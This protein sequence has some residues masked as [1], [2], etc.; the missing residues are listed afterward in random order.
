MSKDPNLAAAFAHLK[1]GRLAEAEQIYRPILER[2]P[3]HSEALHM[4]GV[5]ALQSMKFEA[6]EKLLRQAAPLLPSLPEVHGNLGAAL[7][8]M[9]RYDEAIECY[10]KALALGPNYPFG[11]FRLGDALQARGRFDEALSAYGRAIQLKPDY[12]EAHA[13]VGN[14]YYLLGQ[15]DKAQVS[16]Q[17]ALHLRPDMPEAHNNL[18]NMMQ[19][20]KDWEGAVLCYRRAIGLRPQYPDAYS[21]MSVALLEM[22][23]PREAIEAARQ[24]LKINPNLPGGNN[25]LGNALVKV[26]QMQ[27]AEPYFRKA[28]EVEPNYAEAMVNLGNIYQEWDRHEDAIALYR[29]ALE[30]KP[31]LIGARNNLGTALQAMG[32]LEE[33]IGC[34]RKVVEVQPDHIAAHGN[35]GNALQAAGKPE[36]SLRESARAIELAPGFAEAYCNYANAAKDM[37]QLDTAIAMYRKAVETRPDHNTHSNM[38]YTIHFHPGYDSQAIL[39]ENREWDRIHGEPLKPFIRPHENDRSPDR[40]LRIGYVSPDFRDHCQAFFTDPLFSRHDRSQFEIF[41]YSCVSH[42]DEVTKTLRRKVDHWENILGLTHEGIAERIREDKI[43]ILVDLTM[44][45]A[46]NRLPVFGRRPA[47]VQVSWL[48]YPSTTGME[49]IDYRI[50]DPYLDPPGMYDGDYS[51]KSIRLPDTFWC[52]D[53]T[54]VGQGDADGPKPSILPADLLGYITFGSLNNFCK[55]SD[56][57]LE[58]W[59]KAMK[60]VPGSRMVMLCH[61][62]PG[63]RRV[64]EILGKHGI[65]ADRFEF[66]AVLPRRDYLETY[67]RIDIGLDTIPYNGHTTSLDSFWM[68]VPVVTLIG[69]TIVGRA[70]WSML[71]NLK[72]RELAANSDEEFVKIVADLAGDLPRLAEMRA[73]LRQRMMES[74]LMDAAKFAKNMEAAYRGMWREWCAGGK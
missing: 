6:A 65:E 52:Y 12:A 27:E 58:L 19:A 49:A 39:R 2:Q 30:L 62:G 1:A 63:R 21:N 61:E 60:A 15:L 59:A 73:G 72:M 64:S 7:H 25:N 53:M 34:F 3:Q 22:G 48:A 17:R 45:M 74:P 51:E 16:F 71:S 67:R 42:E 8:A 54:V 20:R 11:H 32:K 40:K 41:C 44:H 5:I 18:G 43:D 26:G 10:R 23:K 38:V 47:P 68:G 28:I 29:Q 4:M 24:A 36:E 70:G 31:N 57:A 55:V 50:T 69:P 66:V 35:L 33:A 13:N 14:V 37:G 56:R 46:H 9:G